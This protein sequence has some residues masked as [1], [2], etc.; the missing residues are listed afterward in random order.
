MPVVD[1]NELVL[2]QKQQQ[3]VR[4]ICILAHVDHGKTT[5]ADSLVASN[6][7]ISQRMAG[8][9]RY[10]D[11]RQDE[12]ERGITM[13][14]S[15]ISLYYQDNS[16]KDYLINLIDSPGHV[17][18]S[19]EVSTAVRLCDGAIVVVDVVEGVGP[20]TRACLKQIYE[21]QLKP[22][23]LLNKLDRLIM[24]KQM[25]PLDAYFHLTQVLEQ[26]NAVL[27]SIFASDVLAKEDLTDKDNYE[28]ALENVDDSE[29]YFSP[30]AGNVVF[31][32]AYDGWAFA[33]SDF[34]VTYAER[35][36]IPRAELEQKLWGDFYYNS[37]KKC[38]MAGA[39]EK[40][41]K[42]MFVQFV[43]ENIWS[44]YDIIAVRKDKEKL[45]LIAEKLG[46]KLAARD[47]RL[48]DA[49]LQIKTVLGQWLPIDRSVLQMVVRHVPPPHCIS[50]ERA[51]RLLYPANVELSSL[52]AETLALKESFRSCNAQSENFIAFVSKMMPVAVEQLPQN[53]PKR[54]TDQELQQ[55]RDEVRRRI[56][57]RK[58]LSEQAQLEQLTAGVEQLNTQSAAAE[59]AAEAEPEP[60]P[61]RKAFEF[62]AFAR[63]FSGTLRRG[64]QLYN[65]TPKHD[66]RQPTHRVLDQ[67][68][69]A[70]QVTV[71]DLY[72]FMGGE[73]QLL[74]EVP[75]GNIVGIGGL[76]SHIVK[77]ATLSS[78]LDCTSFSEL[79]IMATPIL[80]V[81]IEPVQP[82]DMPKLVKGLKLLNQ[83]DACVQ[84]S[85]APTG[86]HVITT[87]GEVHV[88]KCVHDLEQSY[89][90][91]K[92]N[93]S[94]PIV[95][96]RETIVPDATVDMVNEAIVKTADDKDISK[97][98][99]TQQTLNKLGTLRVIALPLPAAVV[100]LLEQH[101][102]V[103]KELAA[104]PR[105]ALLSE[106]FSALLASI[107]SQLVIA[108]SELQLHGLSS[109]SPAELVQR[110]WALGPR[111]CGTNILLNLSD[112][113]QPD[114]WCTQ[115]K[116]DTDLTDPRRDF[117]SSLVNGFQLTTGAGP[118][119][120]EPMQ[121]VCFAVLEWSVQSEGED[122]N[123]RG[124]GPFSG[125]VLTAAKEVCRQAFQNQPQR[126]V[127]PMYSCNIV[128][129]A[130]ML[131]KMYAVIG[132]RHGK[133]L[134]GDLTQGSGNFSV[135]CLL[136][137][138]E[139]FNFAQEIRKQTS[140]LACP[141]LMFSHWEVIDIDPFWLPTTEEELMHF[142]EKADSAN[143]AKLYMDS[144]RRRK[145]LFVDEKVV[146]HAEKQRTLSKNK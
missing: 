25:T 80:R 51:Q 72:M 69:Y 136:P 16:N 13:K 85:V 97:K 32:S 145:G 90:K 1:I 102:N 61:E 22:V 6:G 110:I 127:T 88:D 55:R 139:S 11:S 144:V 64:M 87:L 103:F 62:I 44:L 48:T 15:S 60:E 10:M 57:E 33:V 4:N 143:R 45:P 30:A 120:E 3:Q 47:L 109:L 132:R 82:Q 78:T 121:G 17:D 9:L 124:F 40:A 135:T 142:G 126:L 101:G 128:V 116:S 114:F 107:R 106:K 37:K 70:T 111:N 63:V 130:E 73:L 46:L 76:E 137:V 14:S 39:Q 94:K 59:A 118:L 104:A 35:L 26:V 86:E 138:I 68:P 38:V 79:S 99:A 58:Q 53:R 96:F 23:L 75:A 93:V 41:K 8:K 129:D 24:E 146:E 140:G 95:S 43:L 113:E 112:Y 12:Q 19:S 98:I 133:I 108:F 74:E 117:N 134:S 83:A 27:G 66:P 105:N 115:T 21:E 52:P 92:V 91:I 81:A 100:Q 56:E 141:Q 54:L 49:K 29:L 36:E 28:S 71:G 2:L 31:C 122:L 125:Q 67:A 20:Q 5:L 42:P 18:F 89:A 123:A 34:A 77:T 119:C 84:V 7:I 50:E 131:G 65:L